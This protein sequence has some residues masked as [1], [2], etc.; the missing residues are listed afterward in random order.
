M[1]KVRDLMTKTVASCRLETTLAAAGTL[2][3]ETDCSVLPIVDDHRRVTGMITDRDVCIAVTTSDRRPSSLR[4]GDVAVSQAFA[5]ESDTDIRSALEMMRAHRVH[6]LPVVNKANLLEGM[7]SIIDIARQAQEPVARGR[8]DVS[9]E[10]VVE[11]LQTISAR[12]GAT[13]HSA[14]AGPVI[15]AH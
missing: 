11:T 12:R 4:V 1:M 15:R 14:T 3:W 8:P 7:V 6:R 13:K 2:M 5:C 9:Y 10:D